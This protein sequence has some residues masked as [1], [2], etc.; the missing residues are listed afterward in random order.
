MIPI[1][2][3]LKISCRR[4]TELV[5]RRHLAPLSLTDALRCR[6]HMMMCGA[7]RRY[8][9]HSLLLEQILHRY[10]QPVHPDPAAVERVMKT[11]INKLP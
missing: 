9:S 3:I 5:E 8:E 1:A 6:L 10:H 2:S 11:M 4:A 7:C